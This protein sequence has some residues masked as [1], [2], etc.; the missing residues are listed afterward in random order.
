MIINETESKSILRKNKKIDSWFISYSGM[1]LYRGCSHN[2]V[3]CD[4]RAEKYNV[5]GEFGKDIAVKIN[6]AEILS[7][8]LN[9]KRK[10]KPIKKA[11]ILLGGGVGDS[12]QAPE[13]KYGLSRKTLE[14]INHF[15]YPVHV[16]TKSTFVERDIDL[17]KKINSKKKALVSFS[18]ATS[19]KEIASIFE[20]GLPSPTERLKT[21]SR[22]RNEGISSGIF[23][24][25]VIPYISDSAEMIDDIIKK[26]K[27]AGAQFVIFGGMTLKEGR[28]KDFF[29]NVI[30][31]N[32]PQFKNDYERLYTGDKWGSADWRYYKS[33]NKLF[34]NIAD[35]Y[36]LPKRIPPSI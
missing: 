35:K 10:R 17:L 2:C 13:R 4:G 20:P 3:Y 9:P 23:L 11:F 22:L 18:F 36:S 32:F 28:Q 19:D 12:Y 33:L 14:L 25:P 21:I 16:L 1:N 7:R 8:E 15:N 5:E 34:A 6:A 31:K 29:M 30:N 24:M 26:A 27:E